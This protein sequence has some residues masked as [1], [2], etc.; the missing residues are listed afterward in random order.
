MQGGRA[1]R[2]RKRRWGPKRQKPGCM[3]WGACSP[4]GRGCSKGPRPGK[5]R[6]GELGSW[7]GWRAVP[8]GSFWRQ[9]CSCV[10]RAAAQGWR[11]LLAAE[12]SR[13]RS[14]GCTGERGRAASAWA[15]CRPAR[16]R[17]LLTAAR[18]ACACPR[19]PAAAGGPAGRTNGVHSVRSRKSGFW[20]AGGCGPRGGLGAGCQAMPA[21]GSLG[22]AGPHPAW[23]RCSAPGLQGAGDRGAAHHGVGARGKRVGGI[24][25]GH[26]GGA[27][28][29]GKVHDRRQHGQHVKAVAAGGCPARE[30][31]GGYRATLLSGAR[32]VAAAA[33]AGRAGGCRV[34]VLR[35]RLVPR[36]RSAPRQVGGAG[37]RRAARREGL[38]CAALRR[39]PKAPD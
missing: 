10:G 30:T 11:G 39:H 29:G 17:R 34:R 13:Q 33:T 9:L 18:H 20:V 2:K 36:R 7:A 37:G 3:R 6:K 5:G 28:D 32:S 38:T 31:A 1:V 21:G 27:T 15:G 16:R 19:C 4:A 14:P 8:L 22:R 35:G 23:L 24:W 26:A 25:G 12:A